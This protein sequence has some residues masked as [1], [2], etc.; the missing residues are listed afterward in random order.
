MVKFEVG[1]KTPVG[2]HVLM[3]LENSHYPQDTRVSREARALTSAGYQVSVISPAMR[4]Q[5][6]HESLDG[7][8]VYR[9]PLPLLGNGF[10][11]YLWE[12]GYSMLTIFVLSL[13]LPHH[14]LGLNI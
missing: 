6:W 1:M 8:C 13:I 9:F 4:G 7:V 3:L 11:G 14:T 2:K 5:S 10:L 12:Y